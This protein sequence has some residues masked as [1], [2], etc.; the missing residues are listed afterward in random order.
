MYWYCTLKSIFFFFVLF[1]SVQLLK[2]YFNLSL[3]VEKV[4]EGLK[5]VAKHANP[6]ALA[7]VPIVRRAMGITMHPV[8]SEP[9]EQ[10]EV[11]YFSLM[12]WFV[13]TRT[14]LIPS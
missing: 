9:S 6:G 12:L 3:S 10:I 2:Y 1:I 13:A 11:R 4:T 8:M 7:P 5:M 14:N